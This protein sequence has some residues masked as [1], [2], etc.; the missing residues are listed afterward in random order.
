MSPERIVVSF[1]EL[2]TFRQCPLKHEL[3]YKQRWTKDPDQE[4]PLTKGKLWHAVMETHY[5]TLQQ[6]Q[7]GLNRRIHS[8]AEERQALQDAAE[9]VAPLLSDQVSGEQTELQ[10]LV[11]WMYAGHVGQWGADLPWWII[12]V[13]HSA[14]VPLPSPSGRASPKY[15][16]KIKV[17]LI[18]KDREGKVFVV[19]HKSCANLPTKTQLDIND[20]FGLYT[21]GMRRLGVHVYAALHSAARTTRNRGDVDGTKPQLL[22]DRF[23]RTVTYRTPQ[24]LDRLMLDAANA[25]RAAYS[26]N[27]TYSSPDPDRCRWRCDFLEAHLMARKGVPL[28]TTLRDLGFAVNKDRH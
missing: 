24:E 25:A 9:A 26:G 22:E 4:S 2:D 18:V 10:E 19:D 6:T 3:A 12:A 21:A 16:L 17:D 8:G 14:E 27:A 7:V 20:Q 28:P 23:R 15:A 1:S 13:E 11:E 5:R